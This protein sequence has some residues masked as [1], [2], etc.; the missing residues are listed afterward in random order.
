MASSAGSIAC[1]KATSTS[2]KPKDLR[3]VAARDTIS[4]TNFSGGVPLKTSRRS[5]ALNCIA[6][7]RERT[8]GFPCAS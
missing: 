8:N 1:Q 4:F 2:K 5:L 3:D 7:S 6:T